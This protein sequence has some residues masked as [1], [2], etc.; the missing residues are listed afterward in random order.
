MGA[1]V[2][3]GDCAGGGEGEVRELVGKEAGL[4]VERVYRM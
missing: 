3:G 4:I 1:E 2:K